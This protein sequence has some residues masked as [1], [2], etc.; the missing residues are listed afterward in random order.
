VHHPHQQ[1][2]AAISS[3][4]TSPVPSEPGSDP[5][6]S[7]AAPSPAT[8]P[9]PPGQVTVEGT[10]IG[11]SAVSTD[12]DVTAVAATLGAYFG[13]INNGAYRD[14]WDTFTSSEQAAAAYDGFARNESTTRDSQ[15]T[16]QSIQHD[17]GGNLEANV[18]FQSQ[19]E[20]QYGPNPGET[21]TNWTLDY[22]L[23]PTS[24]SARL[25]YLIDKVTL[26][27]AG[28]TAC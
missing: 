24:G 13:G 23:V 16:V 28:H 20:G 2:A 22:H 8:P 17:G 10:T 25:A 15:V 21:C 12:P 26:I 9:S 14:A 7:S 11:I 1:N 6:S 18:S 4:S 27:G 19:Q 5:A 3:A